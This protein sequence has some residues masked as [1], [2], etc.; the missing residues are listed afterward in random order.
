MRDHLR[1]GE[2]LTQVAPDQFF[3]WPGRDVAGRT[4]LA[5]HQHG[6]L[7]LGAAQVVVV[8]RRHVTSRAATPTSAAAD[9]AA[10]EVLMH[11]VVASCHASIIAQ[12]LLRAIELLLAD[13]GRHGRDRDPFGRVRQPRAALAV[14]DR[15]QGGAAPLRRIPAQPIGEDLP[16]VDGIGQH[17]AQDGG[18]PPPVSPGGGNAK[19]MQMLHQGRHRGALVGEPGEQVADHGGLRLVQPHA[20]WVTR[21][22][23]VEPV[24]VG[25]PRPGQQGAGTQLAQA[26]TP[27]PLGD[28]GSLV[29]GHRAAD[30]EQQLVMRIAAHRP[31]EEVDHR[32][33]LLQLLDQ[34]HLMHVVARQPIR[35]GDQDPV[36]TRARRGIAQAVQARTPEARTTVAVVAEDVLRRQGPALRRGMSAQAVE[37]LLSGLRLGLA[38]GRDPSIR[39]YLH[40]GSPP[41]RPVER[42]GCRSCREVC[43][44]PAEVAGRP[45]PS[46]AV[47]LGDPP[48]VG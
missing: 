16:E 10:Q 36:Q 41:K 11:P 4:P 14:A 7:C 32:P 8:T 33:V 34:Q 28:Q 26:T 22:F 24:A 9:Q 37:L 35:R 46:V 47:P 43:P 19:A 13:D 44:P 2:D 23:G 15:Q 6:Q 5:R 12:P 18:T 3:Q 38:L 31:I 17:A 45:C 25:R 40:G 42:P 1:R 21:P 39:G 20:G 48:A 29:L 30:L 27:H